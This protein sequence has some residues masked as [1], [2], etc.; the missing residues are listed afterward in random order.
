MASSAEEELWRDLATRVRLGVRRKQVALGQARVFGLAKRG[1]VGLVWATEDLS[2]RAFGKLDI[3][4]R[5][6]GVPLV[7]GG[8]MDEV[9]MVTGQPTTKV[10]VLKKSFSGL[11]QVMRLVEERLE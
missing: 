2:R 6:L 10:Y 8:S 1:N 9:G 3:Q 4:C 11:P 7:R 5:D